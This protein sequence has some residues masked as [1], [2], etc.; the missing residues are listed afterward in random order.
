MTFFDC[1]FLQEISMS[2]QIHSNA[3]TTPKIRAE[4]KASNLS[5][6]A[7]ARCYNIHKDTVRK[8]KKRDDFKDR[9]HRPHK[10][11]STLSCEQELIVTDLRKTLLLPLDDLLAITKKFIEPKATRSGIYRLLKRENL[12]DLNSLLAILKP[13][14]ERA[15]KKRFKDYKPGFIHI[16]LK[17]LPKMPDE[18]S[19]RYL[20]VAIDRATRWLFIG[21]YSDQSQASSVDFLRKIDAAAPMKIEELLT[22]NGSQF[23]DRFISNKKN[24]DGKSMPAGRHEFDQVCASLK[25]EHRLITPRHP[26]TNDMVER[27]NDRISEVT[28]QTR[29]ASATEMERTLDSYVRIYNSHIPQKTLGHITPNNSILSWSEKRPDLFKKTADNQT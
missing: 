4:I 1:P 27:F 18:E 14:N 7:L 11:D 17:Y 9:S 15:A 13:E 3:R 23:T 2:H 20:F 25:I 22:D 10:I 21:I 24:E 19:R 16:D 8:W 28:K 29:F 12:N 5:H 6:A 26:Q